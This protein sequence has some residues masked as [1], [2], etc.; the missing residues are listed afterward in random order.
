M[1][2]VPVSKEWSADTSGQ[3]TMTKWW[4]EKK[5]SMHA[6]ITAVTKQIIQN[7]SYRQA[8]NLRHARLYAN[9][10]LVGL[11]AGLYNQTAASSTVQHRVTLNVIR[12]CIDTAV[13]KIGKSK[14][15]PL[16]LTIDGNWGDRR[17][18]KQTTLFFDGWFND[19]NAYEHGRMAFRD[20]CV[21]GTGAV[22]VFSRDGKIVCERVLIDE[23][24]VDDI[25][26]MY[27]TPQNLYQR[28]YIPRAVL[29]DMYP[30]FTFQIDSAPSGISEL[31]YTRTV[32]DMVE[33]WEAWHLPTSKDADDGCHAIAIEGATLFQEK[34]KMPRFPFAFFHW[35][36]R[37]AGF[38]GSGLAEELTGIQLEINKMLMTIQQAQHLMANPQVW[39]EMSN[40]VNSAKVSNLIG[41]INYYMGQPPFY[42]TP[43]AMPSEYYQH[44][45]DLYRKAFEITGT[46]M[47][48]ATAKKPS[49]LDA[50]VALREYQ[51]IESERFMSVALCYEKFYLN[52]AEIVYAE[53]DSLLDEGIDVSVKANSNKAYQKLKWSDV[54]L[55]PDSYTKRVFPV[56][57]L[58]T[59]PQGKLQKVQ[60]LIQSGLMPREEGLAELDFPDTEHWIN[61][62]TAHVN[63]LEKYIDAMLE[64][65]MRVPEPFMNLQLAQRM[66]QNAYLQAINDGA[67]ED[68]IAAL[69]AF[70]DQ[71]DA[72]LAP[73][74]PPI[75]PSMMSAPV[76]PMMDPNAMPVEPMAVPEAPPVS[77]LLPIQGG[78]Q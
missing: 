73:P 74:P 31:G 36:P 27:G 77:E 13:S 38:Y 33:V 75:D 3:D 39:L 34:Y 12:S 46:S 32:S 26:G 11:H 67:P 49:G 5:E 62:A 51:D 78:L 37:L 72:M 24:L 66:V 17:K 18:S 65:E 45:Q 58:P 28:K 25:E 52:I 35:S 44:L 71:V 1:A 59:T 8:D 63:V 47:M 43:A 14:P 50:A 40:K 21:F 76:D 20:G 4:V 10:E 55:K 6:S 48:S 19:S 22:K 42:V 53:L 56:S 69:Q 60:E 64:G 15:R 23:I 54:R 70:M 61:R 68:V 9:R 41:G 57:L 7:Q 30:K 2:N 16:F 29:R